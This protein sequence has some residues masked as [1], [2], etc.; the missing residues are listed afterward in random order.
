MPIRPDLSNPMPLSGSTITP[1]P[2]ALDF[3]AHCDGTYSISLQGQDTSDTTLYNLG[4]T[5]QFPCFQAG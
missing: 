5:G 1:S 3:A 4:T 2:V